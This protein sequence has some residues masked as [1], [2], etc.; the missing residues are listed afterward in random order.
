MLSRLN[1]TVVPL[2]I[3]VLALAAACAPAARPAPTT[4]PAPTDA[5]ATKPASAAVENVLYAFAPG[6]IAIIEPK[7]AQI[8]KDLTDGL[9]GIEWADPVKTKDNRLIFINDRANAQVVVIDTAKHS[10]TKRIDVGPRPVHIYN[11]L[12]DEIWTHSDEEGTFYVIDAKSLEV[13]GKVVA[14]LKNTGHGKLLYHRDLGA[15]AY[16]TN[17]NDPAVFVLDL[18]KKRVTKTIELCNGQGGTHGK[19]Y[20]ALSKHAYFECSG[21]GKTAV[22]DTTTDTLVKY[23]DGSGQIFTS[24]DEKLVLVVAK[25]DGKIHVI[26]ATKGS[27]VVASIPAEGGP[28]K[29]YF[30]E[31]SGKL[32]AFTTNTFT[33][34]TAVLDLQEMKVAKRIA[35]GDI[36]RPEGASSF[37]RDGLMGGG[38]FFTPAS[39][40]GVVSIID[41]NGLRVHA[42]V[43]V[44]DVEKVIYLGAH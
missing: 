1:Q 31:Q 2:L 16:A 30:H 42:T 28:D 10:I 21:I 11:P 38:F 27:T 35:A 24:P 17:T 12:G 29:V 4:A 40:D 20:S 41:A 39:G 15:K 33:P 26:D 25:R 14:A 7:S 13:K 34:D 8:V 43:P 5:S 44:K 3:A 37:H 36:K 18:E 19:A 6:R 22:V 23:M 9:Q 32:Y